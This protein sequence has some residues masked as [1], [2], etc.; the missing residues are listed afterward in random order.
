MQCDIAIPPPPIMKTPLSPNAHVRQHLYIL[1]KILV[2]TTASTFIVVINANNS[3][4]VI[5]FS[6]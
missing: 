6:N 2:T 1:G 4:V 5:I 3:C